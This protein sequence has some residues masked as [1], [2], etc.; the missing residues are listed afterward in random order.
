LDWV[1]GAQDLADLLCP[2]DQNL[3]FEEIPKLISLD[4]VQPFVI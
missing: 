3:G 2:S 4:L 1:A